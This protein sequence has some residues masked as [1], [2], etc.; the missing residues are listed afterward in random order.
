MDRILEFA[1]AN[2]LL[3]FGLLTSFLLVVFSE[4]RRKATNLVA[5]DSADGVKLIN[6]DATVIDLRS[7]E[8]FG[9]GHIVNARNIPMDELAAR[10]EKLAALKSKPVLVVCD[11][12]MTSTKAVATLQQAGFENVY[13]LKGGMN[14]WSQAGLPV[15]TGKKTKSKKR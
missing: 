1:D 7:N 2:R 12:G 3:V 8:S 9:R 5:I 15:V 10:I 4:I 13:S 11:M 14:G 6:N